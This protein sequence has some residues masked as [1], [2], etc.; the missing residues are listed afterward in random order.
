MYSLMKSIVARYRGWLVAGSLGLALPILTDNYTVRQVSQT[1]LRD[2][3]KRQEIASL[4]IVKNRLTLRERYNAEITLTPAAIRRYEQKGITFPS[5]KMSHHFCTFAGS[6]TD[7]VDKWE[8]NLSNTNTNS[9]SIR[10]NYQPQ[11]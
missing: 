3:I 7:E 8:K 5:S 1:Y 10:R 4:L 9:F 11:F 2:L 6:S